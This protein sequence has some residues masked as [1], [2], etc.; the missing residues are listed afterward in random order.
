M[1][2][3]YLISVLL[4]AMNCVSNN[5]E[6]GEL[7]P[8]ESSD[9]TRIMSSFIEVISSEETEVNSSEAPI[10]SSDKQSLISSNTAPSHEPES[11]DDISS[12]SSSS[13]ITQPVPI[14]GTIE[15]S[16]VTVDGYGIFIEDMI[17][18]NWVN[19]RPYV[20][21]G[22]CWSPVD[23][24]TNN[25]NT[26]YSGRVAEDAELMEKIHINAV[27]TYGLLPANNEG[28]EILDK[29]FDHGIRII[30]V[31]SWGGISPDD[32]KNTI[33]HFKDHP[34]ILAWQ[35][36]NEFNYNNLYYFNNLNESKGYVQNLLAIA[37]ETDPNHPTILGWGHPTDSDYFNHIEP[38]EFDILAGQV[39]TGDS[40]GKLFEYHKEFSQK[41]FFISEYGADSYNHNI[42]AEDY[43]SQAYAVKKLVLEIRDNLAATGKGTATTIGGTVFEWND[44]WWKAEGTS[45][46]TQD[47]KGIAPG[48][49]PYPDATFDEEYW[50]IMTIDRSKKS[51]YDAL[52]EAYDEY[53][54]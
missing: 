7:N 44:E 3:I 11:S 29:L 19:R 53:S 10:S 25:Q 24:G 1:R 26:N 43:D 46:D 18:E 6:S 27:R 52:G 4:L 47:V 12:S 35:V 13:S 39:Y 9:N 37:H 5:P 23:K 33:N 15:G 31:A 8:S 38:M 45:W 40:F 50:G 14:E 32:W 16:K 21:K 22:V 54:Y 48:G 42:N 30:M 49:G 28:T 20:I 36:G 34:G 2:Y 17:E 41:P 51:V